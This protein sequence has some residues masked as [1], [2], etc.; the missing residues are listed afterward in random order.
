MT[1]DQDLSNACVRTITNARQVGVRLQSKRTGTHRHAQV[2]ADN[3]TEKGEQTGSS[4]LQVAQAMEEQLK[5]NQQELETREKKRKVEDVQRIR[6]MVHAKR[7][8]QETKPHA[9]RNGQTRAS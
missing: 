6:R 5:E 2:S 7:Q 1:E 9:K 8:K 4:V 3:P